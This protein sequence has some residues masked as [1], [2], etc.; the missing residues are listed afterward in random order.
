MD[1]L[2]PP[3]YI[4]CLELFLTL[5][6]KGV[7]NFDA[8]LAYEEANLNTTVSYLYNKYGLS[9]IRLP[10]EVV[11]PSGGVARSMRYYLEKGHYDFAQELINIHKKAPAGEQLGLNIL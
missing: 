1:K 4:S 5:K 6:N 11:K 2:H 9:F 7:N 8:F 10:E 3:K